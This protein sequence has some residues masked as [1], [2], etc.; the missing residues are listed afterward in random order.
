MYVGTPNSPNGRGKQVKVSAVLAL[1][2]PNIE[3]E[4]SQRYRELLPKRHANQLS[5]AEMAEW[6]QI[7]AKLGIDV[8]APAEHMQAINRMRLLENEREQMEATQIAELPAVRSAEER[9]EAERRRIEALERDRRLV[10]D[11]QQ[12]ALKLSQ[13]RIELQQVRQ[14]NSIIFNGPVDEDRRRQMHEERRKR[15]SRLMQED[16]ARRYEQSGHL[17][18]P[19]SQTEVLAPATPRPSATWV[20]ALPPTDS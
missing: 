3:R 16:Y 8:D 4:F 1:L 11:S 9:L 5:Q 19:P 14:T 18:E 7:V 2:K 6:Q 10:E 12:R 17:A 13:V 15:L 20:S